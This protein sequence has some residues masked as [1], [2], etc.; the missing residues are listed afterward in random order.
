MNAL[1]GA[2][3]LVFVLGWA[4]LSDP[5]HPGFGFL[6]PLGF[7]QGP[8]QALSIGGA[9]EASGLEHGGQL[10]LIVAAGGYAWCCGAGVPLI[11]YARRRDW[12]SSYAEG[13]V[14]AE[15]ETAGAAPGAL[16]PLTRQLVA[17]GLVYALTYAILAQ[18]ASGLDKPQDI[19]LVWGFH[20][21]TAALLAIGA[22]GMADRA[23]PAALD[24]RL[25][26]RVA[27]VV[28][29]VTTCAAI[30]AVQ[31]PVLADWWLPLLLLT[32][33]GGAITLAMCGLAAR[34][35]FPQA[36]FE[37]ALALFGICTGTLPTG[38]ALLRVV[39]PDLR[40]PVARNCIIG[41]AAAVPMA[42]PLL[43][44][45][46]PLPVRGWP[47]SFPGATWLGLGL[48][49]VY[50]ALLFAGWWRFGARRR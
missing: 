3:G 31:L 22:R 12:I 32:V 47:D 44:V 24:N 16:E 1:Q 50:I 33:G 21:I 48:V 26:G 39:D 19:A 4:A 17:I 18:A 6:L 46:M 20:F 41:S 25:L 23:A 30:A 38:L 5:I 36:S 8:G 13:E 9:W 28:V 14:A 40:G 10:G 45:V 11:W 37:H 15:A 35:A 27:A 2:V 29:D 7:G 42:V 34:Y 49:T 43:L